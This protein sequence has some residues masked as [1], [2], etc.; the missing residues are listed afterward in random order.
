MGREGGTRFWCQ[1]CVK[2]QPFSVANDLLIQ[3]HNGLYEADGIPFRRRRKY[4]TK[5]GFEIFTAELDEDYLD[6]F[7]DLRRKL[8]SIQETLDE[9]VSKI[10]ASRDRKRTKLLEK[11]EALIKDLGLGD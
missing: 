6:E 11:A 5:C 8:I 7:L 3:P 2:I 4:C 9:E 1:Q 10:K